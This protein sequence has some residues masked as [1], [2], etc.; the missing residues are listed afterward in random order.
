MLNG[1]TKIVSVFLGSKRV[2]G[3]EQN[4]DILDISHEGL[5]IMHGAQ[6]IWGEISDERIDTFD[7]IAE[8]L[9][10]HSDAMDGLRDGWVN[11]FEAFQHT[12]KDIVKR[13]KDGLGEGRVLLFFLHHFLYAGDAFFK[14]VE[15]IG[16][17]SFFGGL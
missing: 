16:L 12:G 13:L 7:H 8:F 14:V 4:L 5:I 11:L 2:Q 9:K 6:I 10:A 17:N 1:F 3:R 15:F